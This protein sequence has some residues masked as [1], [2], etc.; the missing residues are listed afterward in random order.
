MD[1]EA[2]FELG[3]SLKLRSLVSDTFAAIENAPNLALRNAE[4]SFP[5]ELEF[6]EDEFEDAPSEAPLL[7]SLSP[8]KIVREYEDAYASPRRRELDVSEFESLVK[9]TDLPSYFRYKVSLYP[10]TFGNDGNELT[11]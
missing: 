11:N 8:K 6:S 2:D 1:E 5:D 3:S 10:V 9:D 4:E 7:R